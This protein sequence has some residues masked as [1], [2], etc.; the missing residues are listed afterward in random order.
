MPGSLRGILE[1][2]DAF[3]IVGTWDVVIEAPAV[4]LGL[5]ERRAGKKFVNWP[6]LNHTNHQSLD[7]RSQVFPMRPNKP[8]QPRR[9]S[10]QE[11]LLGCLGS[12][13]LG[14]NGSYDLELT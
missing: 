10:P 13:S 12:H 11:A 4:G 8:Q 1:V 9:V 7:K 3:A 5:L 6:A 14:S 2:C